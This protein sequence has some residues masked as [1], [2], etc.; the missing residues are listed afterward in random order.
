MS[1]RSASPPPLAAGS[2][3]TATLG[4]LALT[5]TQPTPGVTDPANNTMTAVA[6]G[7][8][9]QFNLGLGSGSQSVAGKSVA[10]I[11]SIGNVLSS[12]T[13]GFTGSAAVDLDLA[14]GF[15]LQKTGSSY[16]VDAAYPSFT[17]QLLIGGGNGET[18]WS[19]NVN[20]DNL[21]STSVAA[22][23][24]ALNNIEFDFGSFIDQYVGSV[25]AP[26]AKA[27]KPNRADPELPQHPGTDL[28]RKPDRLHRL[29]G[30][31]RG[32]ER[33]P[34][35]RLRHHDRQLCPILRRQRRQVD[36]SLGNFNLSSFDLR[37]APRQRRQCHPVDRV[38][39]TIPELH[40]HLGQCP[41]RAG[42]PLRFG[43]RRPG[44]RRQFQL[45][46][47]HE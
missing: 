19:L 25:L 40:E 45:L 3:L 42:L 11:A 14:L 28:Q 20:S 5:A 17:A 43:D 46:P 27:L 13:I 22:P 18:P 34:V 1:C 37:Q 38:R 31:R 8:G 33:R 7:V 9:L 39:L 32:A 29:A 21:G 35:H 47:V 16:Q 15:D 30:R 36:V 4:F 41:R 24:V 2:E 44:E 6:T 23:G 10:P 26:I 12:A